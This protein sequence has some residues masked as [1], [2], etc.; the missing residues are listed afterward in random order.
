[1]NK[2]EYYEIIE[3]ID[4][5]LD[6]YESRNYDNT[7][8]YIDLAS[9]DTIS[10]RFDRKNIPHLLGINTDYLRTTGMFTGNAYDIL[11]E[12]TRNPITLYNQISHGYISPSKVFSE[13][14]YEK[15][16]N[17]KKICKIHIFD[18]EFIVKYDKNKNLLS[19]APLD[20]GYYIGYLNGKEL[21]V[22]GFEKNQNTYYPHTS[23]LFE[24]DSQESDYFLKRLM[25]NQTITVIEIMKKN[26]LNDDGYIDKKS[27][28]YHN[29]EKQ[30]KLRGCK[31]YADFYKGVPCTISSNIFYVDKV[32][33][34]NEEKRYLSEALAE[35]AVKIEHGKM[36][37]LNYLRS[38]YEVVDNSILELVSAHNDSLINGNNTSDNEYSYKD[39][40][41]EYES[42]KAE[43]ARLNLLI[44]KLSEKEKRLT[45][46]N[47]GL[48]D[49]NKKLN[50]EREQIIKILTR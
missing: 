22:V 9:G 1:M 7:K 41:S 50:E 19:E 3:R 21:N 33:N 32:V 24:R 37:D 30:S 34:L 5:C 4:D 18:I 43:I 35:I 48:K 10:I 25:T 26:I 16:D 36:I 23:L 46:E 13:H 39:L 44:E 29:S 17:F 42:A 20:D 40:I 11:D 45:E 6:Y 2:E 8:F 12:I 38:K 27:Y 47:C 31:R 14:I 28:Y 15:L 49:E